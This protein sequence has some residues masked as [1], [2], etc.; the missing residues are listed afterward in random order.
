MNPER[1]PSA[2]RHENQAELEALGNEK[3]RELAETSPEAAA[4]RPET[5]AERA[6]E[7]LD[8]QHNESQPEPPASGEH[9][10]ARPTFKAHLDRALNYRQTLASVQRTLSPASRSFSKAIHQPTVERVSESMERTIMRPSV[11]LGAT[12]TALIV[13]LVFYL[14]A[15]HYG[16]SMSGSE[17]LLALVVGALLG[18]IFEY[19]LRLIRKR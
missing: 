5:R 12:W 2:E 7:A 4:E 15:K 10:A 3:L 17:M 18:I 9:K 11:T 6:R 13:G 14:T 16:Y 8:A 19:V 1:Q